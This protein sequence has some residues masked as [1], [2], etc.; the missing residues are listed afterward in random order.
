MGRVEDLADEYE[1]HL[2]GPW[3]HT[4]AGAQRIVFVVYQK[5][6]ER[7]LRAR[8]GSERKRSRNS[9]APRRERRAQA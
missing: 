6:D 3:Q 4:L 2:G 5:E 7:S 8:L 9:S 1:R